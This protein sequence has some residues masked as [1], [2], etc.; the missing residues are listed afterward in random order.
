MKVEELRLLTVEKLV[1]LEEDAKWGTRDG[2][3]KIAEA[4][5]SR[6]KGI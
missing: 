5:A 6:V 1:E 2:R 3:E 4:A